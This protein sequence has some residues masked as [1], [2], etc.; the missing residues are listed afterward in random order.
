MNK[1][2]KIIEKLLVFIYGI[3]MSMVN[4]MLVVVMI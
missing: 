1:L 4:G 2:L 3:I